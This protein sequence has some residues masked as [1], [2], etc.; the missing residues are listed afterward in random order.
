MVSL[1]SFLFRNDPL[2]RYFALVKK[3]Y[4]TESVE[5]SPT[6][7]AISTARIFRGITVDKNGLILSQNARAT[8]SSRGKEKSKQAVGSRQQEKINKAKDL[9]DETNGGGG[10][11]SLFFI[12]IC[13]TRV[14]YNVLYCL[15]LFI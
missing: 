13:N 3:S 10:K 4:S 15:S 2:L 9:V 5:K 11:V 7:V 12:L 14:L 1:F 6:Q 8:R